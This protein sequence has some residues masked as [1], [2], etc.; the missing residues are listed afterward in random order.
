V[1]VCVCVSV[2]PSTVRRR[3]DLAAILFCMGHDGVLSI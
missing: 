3:S 2:C 1:C